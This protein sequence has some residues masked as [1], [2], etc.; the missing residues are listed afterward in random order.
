MAAQIMEATSRRGADVVLN[1]V[2]GDTFE[3]SLA[4]LAHRGRLV[5][6][7]SPARRRP[8]VDLLDFYHNESQMFG[9]D[10]LAHD[11]VA[12][13]KILEGIALYRTDDRQSGGARRR[14]GC[15]HGRCCGTPR[16]RSIVSDW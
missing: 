7:A 8:E 6:L 10:T 12:S 2:G 5:V 3:P 11:M 14:R 1:A 4:T 9:V 15:L 16:P 13:V